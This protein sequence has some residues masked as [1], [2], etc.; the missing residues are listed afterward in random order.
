M[1]PGSGYI[2]HQPSQT[3]HTHG[4]QVAVFRARL[5]QTCEVYDEGGRQVQI[6]ME[7]VDR[8]L[9]SRLKA[10]AGGHEPHD[11]DAAIAGLVE[12]E[13]PDVLTRSEEVQR[14][15]ELIAEMPDVREDR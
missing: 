14:V 11:V 13:S 8:I 4:C 6:S 10:G 3:S 1:V 15:K 9:Q 2:S 5:C 7:E 12:A